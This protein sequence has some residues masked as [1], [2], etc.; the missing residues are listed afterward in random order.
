MGRRYD[1]SLV[2]GRLFMSDSRDDWLA[3]S[4]SRLASLVMTERGLSACPAMDGTTD[5]LVVGC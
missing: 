5:T 4:A 1:E 2:T 3:R